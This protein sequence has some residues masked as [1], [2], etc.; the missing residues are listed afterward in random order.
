MYG[1]ICNWSKILPAFVY[2]ENI[3]LSC[4]KQKSVEQKNS[5]VLQRHWWKRETGKEIR[6]QTNWEFEQNGIKRLN[7][8]Y[9][10]HIFSSK[11]RGS[12]AFA[13]EQ[14]IREFKKLLFKTKALDK[15]LGR[16]SNQIKY[17]KDDKQFEH[18]KNCK[19]VSN[20]E[21]SEIFIDSKK[22]KKRCWQKVEIR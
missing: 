4:E 18:H 15:K 22:S 1:K 10:M 7:K 13:A 16:K 5:V 19:W 2:L 17:W 14:K 6:I 11:V 12:K 20:L 9:N 21:R 3:H 8:K